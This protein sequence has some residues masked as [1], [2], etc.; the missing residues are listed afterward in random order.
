MRWLIPLLLLS[1]GCAKTVT[2]SGITSWYG[3]ELAGRPTA[4]GEPFRPSHRTAAHRSLPF[5]TVILVR[6][7]DNGRQVKV[8]INDRGPGIE[9]RILDV[10]RRAARRL[11]MVKDGL[12]DIEIIVVGCRSRY[13]DCQR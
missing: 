3:A 9:S 4:S 6:R 1:P 2:Q 13:E 8:V 7:P 5:G 11:D 12:A 10:S